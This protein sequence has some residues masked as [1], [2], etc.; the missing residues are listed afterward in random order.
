MLELGKNDKFSDPLARKEMGGLFKGVPP[1]AHQ[2]KQS[3]NPKMKKVL[4]FLYKST[5]L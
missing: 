1:H 5:I 3:N 4:S 2:A